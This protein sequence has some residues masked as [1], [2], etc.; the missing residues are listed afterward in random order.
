[1]NDFLQWFFALDHEDYGHF[2]QFPLRTAL[3]PRRFHGLTQGGENV[4]K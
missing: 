2:L 4:Q 3:K 1:M